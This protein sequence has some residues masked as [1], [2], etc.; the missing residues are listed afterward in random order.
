MARLNCW[1]TESGCSCR[2]IQQNQHTEL[3]WTHI[4]THPSHQV[5]T[6][7]AH[8]IQHTSAHMWETWTHIYGVVLFCPPCLLLL[9]LSLS[10]HQFSSLLFSSI[11]FSHLFILVALLFTLV[12]LS[13]AATAELWSKRE[14]SDGDCSCCKDLCFNQTLTVFGV[15]KNV[16]EEYTSASRTMLLTQ[17]IDI[18]PFPFGYPLLFK[19]V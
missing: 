6:A 7:N 2:M 16:I 17:L 13:S 1:E 12:I 9:L 10:A 4:P 19:F 14:K 18:K 8:G 3:A 15:K 11:L 5:H